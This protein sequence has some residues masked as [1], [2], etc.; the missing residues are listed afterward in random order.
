M[1][2]IFEWRPQGGAKPAMAGQ[3]L[4]LAFFCVAAISPAAA[5]NDR[6]RLSGRWLRTDGWPGP[7]EPTFGKQAGCRGQEK[8]FGSPC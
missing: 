2:G 7:P 1:A 6:Q 3:G 5:E 4:A 8:V